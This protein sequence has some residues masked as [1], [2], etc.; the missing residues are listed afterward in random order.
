[1][2]NN[3]LSKIGFVLGIISGVGNIFTITAMVLFLNDICNLFPAP[4]CTWGLSLLISIAAIILTCIGKKDE[5]QAE[6][7]PAFITSIAA[8][9]LSLV[10]LVFLILTLLTA[11]L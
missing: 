8:I 3:K 10:T 1:M 11:A 5:D 4:L 2:N 6:N 7:K 9:C